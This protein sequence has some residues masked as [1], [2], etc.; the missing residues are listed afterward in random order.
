MIAF[1]SRVQPRLAFQCGFA[2]AVLRART[3]TF[4]SR[5]AAARVRASDTPLSGDAGLH[6]CDSC[7]APFGRE[8]RAAATPFRE[9]HQT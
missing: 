5:V 6:G 3:K 9:G 1:L 7:A 8:R 4:L 2:S